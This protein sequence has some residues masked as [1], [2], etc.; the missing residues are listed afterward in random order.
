MASFAEVTGLRWDFGVLVPG[1]NYVRSERPIKVVDDVHIREDTGFAWIDTAGGRM[2]TQRIRTGRQAVVAPRSIAS[3]RRLLA[4]GAPL[5]IAAAAMALDARAQ[6][7]ATAATV[8]RH[9]ASRASTTRAA[10]APF[11]AVADMVRASDMAV[12]HLRL[13]R[14]AILSGD[15]TAVI[16]GRPETV[17]AENVAVKADQNALFVARTGSDAKSIALPDV[18]RAS[19]PQGSIASAKQ[20]SYELTAPS[21]DPG[22]PLH[23]VALVA[24]TTGLVL[25]T[26]RSAFR[27]EFSVALSNSDDPSDTRMPQS[28]IAISVTAQ[29]ASIQ[30]S[31]LTIPDVGRWHP[32]TLTVPVFSGSSYRIAV[33]AG[34]QDKGNAIDLAVTQPTV[35]LLPASLSITGWG[36]GET[37]ITLRVMGL[38]APQGYG[39]SFSHEGGYLD[40]AFVQLDAQG[41]ATTALR[42]D[43][44]AQAVVRVAD[45]GLLSQPVTIQFESPWLFIAAAVFGGLAGAF[46]LGKGRRRWPHAL[47]IGICA[48]VVMT[49]AYAVGIDWVSRVINA[50]ALAKSGVAL[51]FVLGALAALTGV[52]VLVPK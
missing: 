51:V 4:V 8:A 28:P 17:T 5:M 43:T 11:G 2:N 29:G 31:P 45:A 37:R 34:T 16:D 24:A 22:A 35:Q 7:H 42:S 14:T 46:L 10:G 3:L 41:V 6:E 15:V 9:D 13:D 33:S 20:L 49:L 12:A 30:P 48:A 18:L 25:D 47:A 44:A 39:V 50:P 32:V 21:A 27:G 40:P 23:L 52:K 1:V 19:L 26:A 38:A 36:I